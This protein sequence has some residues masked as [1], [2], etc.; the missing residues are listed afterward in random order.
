ME[1]RVYGP[2]N[3]ETVGTMGDLATTLSEERHLPEAEKIQRD[4]LEVQKRVLGPEAHYTLASMDNLAA[5]LLYE[6]RQE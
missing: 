6:G 1:R 5:T 3:Q 2:E 4:V